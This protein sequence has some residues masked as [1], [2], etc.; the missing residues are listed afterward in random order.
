MG[1]QGFVQAVSGSA[2]MVASGS[3]CYVV[4]SGAPHA[5]SD[6]IL[7]IVAQGPLVAGGGFAGISNVQDIAN[8]P[9][10]F[11]TGITNSP[12]LRHSLYYLQN[13]AP[14]AQN[15]N[16]ITVQFAAPSTNIYVRFVEF[17]GVTIGG[18]PVDISATA[19]GQNNAPT[20]GPITPNLGSDLLFSCCTILPGQSPMTGAGAGWTLAA[21]DS[22]GNVDQYILNAPIQS[23]TGSFAGPSPS[24]WASAIIGLVNASQGNAQLATVNISAG[25]GVTV[26][27]QPTYGGIAPVNPRMAVSP[28]AQVIMSAVANLI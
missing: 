27:P 16:K 3:T 23:Y 14:C 15:A 2:N 12:S 18:S 1:A 7:A 11:L 5:L 19:V 20:I 8:G 21:I 4:N 22:N 25:A 26:A 6:F 24:V 28:T 10:I 13:S 9:Y 17:A